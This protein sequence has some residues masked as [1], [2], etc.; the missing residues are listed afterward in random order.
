MWENWGWGMPG[1]FGWGGM[2]LGLFVLI[3]LVVAVIAGVRSFLRT[4]HHPSATSGSHEENALEVL[5][6]R[7]ARGEISREEYLRIRED[8]RD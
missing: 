3:G 4:E 5:K 1:Y 6:K 2:V 7:Y 8:L